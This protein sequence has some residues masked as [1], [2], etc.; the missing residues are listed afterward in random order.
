MSAKRT[1]STDL[2]V[3]RVNQ[4]LVKSFDDKYAELLASA[5]FLIGV[6]LNAPLLHRAGTGIR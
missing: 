2:R 6:L 3:K 4:D 1:Y 5:S